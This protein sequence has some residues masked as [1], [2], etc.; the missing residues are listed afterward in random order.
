MSNIRYSL[1]MA[2]CSSM[3]L[4]GSIHTGH[5]L[6]Q[7]Q[8]QTAAAATATEMTA[9]T[10]M[11]VRETGAAQTV[12][13]GQQGQQEGFAVR[14]FHLDLRIQVMTLPALEAFAQK[15][16]N[17]GINT[18]IMEYEA[19]Y[20]YEQHPLIAGRYAYTKE[21]I[22]SLVRFCN[23]LGIDLI[24]LQQS[25]GHVDYI[26]RNDRYAA[27]REDEKDLS[28]ICPLETEK[29]SIL[30]TALFK[31][32]ASTHTSPYIHIGCD[33]THLLGHCPKC[34][35]KAAEEGISKLYLDYVKM[36]CNIVI[37]LGKRP[38]LWADI[39]LKYPDALKSL[40]KETIFVD[41]NYGWDMN[42]FGNH[43][44]LVKSGYEIWG[45]PAL[46]SHPD[47]FF[48]T[49]WEK[50]FKN[51]R[52]FVPACRGLGY[53]GI[54]MTSWSTSGEYSAVY[55]S[56][57]GLTDLFAVRHVYPITGFNILLAAYAKAITDP[58]PLKIEDFVTAYC[59]SQYGFDKA[60]A[61]DFWQALKTAPYEVNKGLVR[62][63]PIS[64]ET[65][66]DSV[67]LASETFNR[68]KPLKNQ[69]EFAHYRLMTDIRLQY[70][71]L[72][73]IEKQV[74][75]QHFH[76]D[77]IPP[78]LQKLKD[79]LANATTLD[80]RFIEL[81]K[82]DFYLSELQEENRVRNRRLQ[83]LYERLGRIR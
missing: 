44:K 22:V 29:D 63:A 66:T 54:V 30:F 81:N 36:L 11:T 10:K 51:I 2:L 50:H 15:L 16:H 62:G 64:L 4:I 33:E 67:R 21:E 39:A 24:P 83:A 43:E 74:N 46:R 28:Q 73:E 53:K 13:T 27:L 32:L 38:I 5:L 9:Q 1:K 76:G 41:W 75:D 23:G 49:Q 60:Q 70:L 55:E 52:S 48:L 58:A 20:P 69:D 12:E 6:G 14:A 77:D 72:R 40:P 80:Q 25:F 82:S 78:V 37:K 17:A 3:I 18:L 42:E 57:D 19:N 79:L 56:E 8:G 59:A 68:L 47:N 71:H 34:R 7:G 26:L 65:L 31:E 61:M 45:A 35:K